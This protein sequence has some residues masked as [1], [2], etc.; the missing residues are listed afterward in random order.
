MKKIIKNIAICITLSVL[1][2]CSGYGKKLDYKGTEVYY[3]SN[4]SKVDAEKLGNYLIKSEF[5]DGGKKSIQLTKNNKTN[6]YIFRMVITKKASKS[7]SYE[8]IFKIFAK[9][10]SDSV[11]NKQPVDFHIC[12]NTFNTL[13]EIPFEKDIL[14]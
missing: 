5:S 14:K 13:K 11:F 10:I 3:T 7:K 6:A 2:S 12:D 9:Q 1:I 8:A 4:V